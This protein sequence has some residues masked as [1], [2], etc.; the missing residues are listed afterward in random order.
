VVP[1]EAEYGIHLPDEG[2]RPALA[3]GLDLIVT[4]PDPAGHADRD[5]GGDE[6]VPLPAPGGEVRQAEREKIPDERSGIFFYLIN[7]RRRPS[8]GIRHDRRA[9]CSWNRIASSSS[10]D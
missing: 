9:A 6:E 1:G 5:F 2:R 8:H 10:D 3:G 4:G 7:E